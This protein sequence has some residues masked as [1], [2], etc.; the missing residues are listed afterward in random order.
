MWHQLEKSLLFWWYLCSCQSLQK[1]LHGSASVHPRTTSILKPISCL[2]VASSLRGVWLSA[3]LT[4]GC[5]LSLRTSTN[6]SVVRN[7]DGC[8]QKHWKTLRDVVKF[9]VREEEKNAAA[10]ILMVSVTHDAEQVWHHILSPSQ[11]AALQLPVRKMCVEFLLRNQLQL[12]GE[13][14]ISE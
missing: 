5:C 10:A 2:R 11:Q 1:T 3:W 9:V 7:I 13:R 12:C 6:W 14:E 4:A 8:P